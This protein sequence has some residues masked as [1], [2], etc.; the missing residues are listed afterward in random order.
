MDALI[1]MLI[2]SIF[3]QLSAAHADII[4]VFK[5][6]NVTRTIGDENAVTVINSVKRT[7]IVLAVFVVFAAISPIPA[8]V[9]GVGDC[10][11]AFV[12]GAQVISIVVQLIS[13]FLIIAVCVEYAYVHENGKIG[14]F[15]DCSYHTCKTITAG[16]LDAN[17]FLEKAV[18][19]PIIANVISIVTSIPMAVIACILPRYDPV[20]PLN[21]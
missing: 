1:V 15:I 2:V 9:R 8:L 10:T 4:L 12:F 20:T 6:D 13:T 14:D 18:L 5:C 16:S 3:I 19:V 7:L 11:K 17:E 21:V